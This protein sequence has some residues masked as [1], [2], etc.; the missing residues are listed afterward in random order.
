M[1][2]IL[3]KINFSHNLQT[4]VIEYFT[5]LK[6]IVKNMQVLLEFM[7]SRSVWNFLIFGYIYISTS[8]KWNSVVF[9]SY[10]EIA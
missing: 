5:I 10:S 8:S 3:S 6:G 1:N 9:H 7:V 2:K 4:I